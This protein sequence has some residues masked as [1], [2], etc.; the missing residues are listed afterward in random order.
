MRRLILLSVCFFFLFQ[1]QA[2]MRG[3]S[4]TGNVHFYGSAVNA[5]CA[6]NAQSLHQSVMM[7][8]VKAAAFTSLGS[9]AAPKTFWIKLESCNATVS[10]SA[11]VAFTGATDPND[12]QVFQAGWGVD[13]AKGVG[14]GIFDDEGTLVVPDSAPVNKIMITNGE[15]I[16]F[17]TAKYRAVS[18]NIVPGD[19]STAVNFAVYYQ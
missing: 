8:P 1:S 3:I 12:P 5:A 15:T 10:Q 9:W 14:I 6:I 11:S 2:A 4:A 18:S 19:A 13:S 7:D 17:F 16:L